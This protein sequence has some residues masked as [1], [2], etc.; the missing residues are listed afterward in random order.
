MFTE[1]PLGIGKF[2]RA[3][4]PSY[5]YN[6]PYMI[7]QIRREQNVRPLPRP[8][9]MEHATDI[10]TSVDINSLRGLEDSSLFAE[11]DR[12]FAGDIRVDR[13]VQHPR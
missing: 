9:I 13:R 11:F 5:V 4:I 7:P 3:Y 8:Q 1:V 2:G 12:W 6:S 10:S